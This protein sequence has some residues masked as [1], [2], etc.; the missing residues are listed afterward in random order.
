MRHFECPNCSR[1]VYFEND[2][3][4]A[5]GTGLV[6]S[7]V[8]LRMGRLD[9]HRACANRVFGACNWSVEAQQET[10]CTA[11]RLNHTVPDLNVPENLRRWA[12]IERAKHRLVYDLLRLGLPV[13]SRLEDAEGLSFDFLSDFNGLAPVS[14]GHSSGV[15]TLNVEEADDAVRESRRSIL[16]EP[17][18]TLLGHFRHEIGHFYWDRLVRDGPLLLPFRAVFG[19]ERDDYGAALQR[20]YAQ[21]SPVDWQQSFISSYASSH[22]WEDWAEC[23]AHFLHIVSTLDTASELPLAVSERLSGALAD[24]YREPDFDALITAWLPLAEALNELNRS[25]GIMDAYPFVLSPAV[26][27][28]L[29]TVH[30]IL[31]NKPQLG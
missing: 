6:F 18:R 15:I 1:R 3:C 26:I 13:P 22:P 16:H 17:Y 23:F 31:L 19:D 9:A 25:M 20:Y 5:C 7:P 29:H 11:C 8:S 21:G 28:K 10:F 4:S 12:L 24:P 2:L 27:G 30:M 14:T